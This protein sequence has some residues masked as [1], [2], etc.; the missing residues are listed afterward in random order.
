[1]SVKHLTYLN[2][3][4]EQRREAA[5]KRRAQL[6]AMLANPLMEARQVAVVHEQLRMLA[7]WEAGTV[8]IEGSK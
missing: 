1:M 3:S 7:A 8:K 2:L 4:P 5:A 6:K